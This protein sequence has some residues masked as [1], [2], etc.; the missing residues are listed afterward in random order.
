M[1]SAVVGNVAGR[2]TTS[3]IKAS[4]ELYSKIWACS[5]NFLFRVRY[6]WDAVLVV[7][8]VA[9]DNVDSSMD[10]VEQCF[11]SPKP[12]SIFSKL[13]L[14]TNVTYMLRHFLYHQH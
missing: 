12:G 5:A 9:S 1:D 11:L 14:E 3:E 10:T 6:V 4:S 13:K 7:F 8:V 2:S